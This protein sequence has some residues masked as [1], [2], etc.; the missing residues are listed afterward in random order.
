VAPEVV[1]VP[2]RRSR[3]FRRN[4]TPV[5]GPSGQ[6]AL[7]LAFGIVVVLDDDRVDLRIDLRGAGDG[8]VEQ[9]AGRDFFLPNQFGKADRVVIAVFLEGHVHTSLAGRS[10]DRPRPGVIADDLAEHVLIDHV[11]THGIAIQH[12]QN[13]AGGLLAHPVHGFHRDASDMRRHDDVRQ[14]EQGLS[15]RRGLL[16]ENVEAGTGKLA[17]DQR[18]VQGRPRRRFRRA[19]C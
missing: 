9:F 11:L 16:R 6:A 13:V 4:G 17:G 18:G 3:S 5:K 19:P 7:D 10:V 14:G 1:R 12:A 8:L 2:S 15:G